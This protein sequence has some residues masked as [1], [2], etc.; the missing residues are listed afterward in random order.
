MKS[1]ASAALYRGGRVL[2]ISLSLRAKLHL[3]LNDFPWA[4]TE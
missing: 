3:N 4:E 2:N 1:I